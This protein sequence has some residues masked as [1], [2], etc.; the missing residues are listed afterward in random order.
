MP[1]AN[2]T[3]VLGLASAGG[4]W[5]QLRRLNPAFTG[6]E[7]A[8]ASV[9]PDY[10]S[11]VPGARY[12]VFDDVNRFNKLSTFKVAAQ[13]ARIIWKERPD[14][15]ITTGAG[16]GLIALI[17]A[18]YV[19][20]SRTIWVDSVANCQKLSSSGEV[21]GRIADI[22]LTQWQHLAGEPGPK[23]WGSVL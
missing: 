22:W 4:H 19:F 7:V 6:M 5:V 23:H 11:D 8:Y 1:E 18:K 12:Y 20:R 21:A 13:I 15:V 16:P 9:F 3:R 2:K 17:L 14:V 10:A